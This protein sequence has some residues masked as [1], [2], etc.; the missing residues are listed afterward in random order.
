MITI[1]RSPWTRA[2]PLVIGAS[3]ALGFCI[4]Q[5]AR[6]ITES[7][8]LL[9]PW[10]AGGTV[11]AG[12]SL[13]LGIHFGYRSFAFDP[14][15][16][17][18]RIGARTVP[19]DSMREA[20]RSNSA[21]SNGAAYLTYRFRSTDGPVVR[22]LVAGRPL[23]G[24]DE[25]GRAALVRFLE[26]APITLPVAP[27]ADLEGLASDFLADGK[28]VPVSA[29]ALLR[30]LGGAPNEPDAVAA[31]SSATPPP[32]VRL[33]R[34]AAQAD[35]VAAAEELARTGP[36]TALR[37][38]GLVF[39]VSVLGLLVLIVVA[40]VLNA[41][42]VDIDRLP[43]TGPIALGA[44][45]VTAIAGLIWCVV[46]DFHARAV[47]AAA[48]RWLDESDADARARGLPVLYQS[49]WL[50][51]A[52]GHRTFAVA[53]FTA[54]VVGLLLVIAGP[55]AA[56]TGYPLV[57]LLTF[58]GLVL[59]GFGVWF[60]FAHRRRRRADVLWVLEAAGARNS[61]QL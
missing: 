18:V 7:S 44:M 28:H 45:A 22:V 12:A 29:S 35:D 36:R 58:P 43:Q 33:D 39:G 1:Q 14:E 19:L 47:R 37:V 24:L 4:A 41:A 2:L 27:E 11:V 25:A 40:L 5:I 61:E 46:G 16:R 3:I 8:E 54:A 26:I 20:T 55:V 50:Q 17:T 21:A 48:R 53:A 32:A 59:L 57:G 51:F 34:R 38:T 13:I 42:G 60:W 31:G 15:S 52:P 9:V 30:D 56:S 6:I 23:P 10:W 49:A